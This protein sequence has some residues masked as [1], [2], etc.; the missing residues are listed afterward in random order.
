MKDYIALMKPGIIVGN[1]ITAIAGFFFASKGEMASKEWIG[2]VLGLSCV[3]GSGCVFNNYHDRFIDER[4]KRTEKRALV[5][6]TIS[7][8]QALLF[9]S[10][11]LFLGIILLYTL[12]N[13]LA[14][15]LAAL[16]FVGYVL[17][18]TPM[19]IRSV[20]ATLIGSLPGAIPPIVGYAAFSNQF[21]F[22]AF[23][24]F[25]IV[26]FW[27]MP[28]FYA[29]SLYRMDEYRSAK[30]PIYPVVKGVFAT[31]LQMIFFTFAFGVSAILPWF[32]GYTGIYYMIVMSITSIGWM[33]LAIFGLKKDASID[34]AKKMF[35]FS[36]IIIM[37]F[38][39]M[40]SIDAI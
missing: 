27:Q 22:A 5:K 40:L 24:L 16:G 38:S 30:I 33:I 29:I 14:T 39:L 1:L 37:F 11:L 6:G 35:R 7:P 8:N 2:M 4:M 17:I 28:H 3:I 21:N 36:L 13:P 26:A 23:L 34:W 19:K 31:K 32:F 10:L 9:G 25:L 15:F 12:T 20:Y 18:Y